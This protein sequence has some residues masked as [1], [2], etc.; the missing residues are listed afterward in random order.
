MV[1][2]NG[3]LGFLYLFHALYIEFDH[4]GEQKKKKKKK[5]QTNKK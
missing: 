4:D 1:E 5:N 3:D 2:L